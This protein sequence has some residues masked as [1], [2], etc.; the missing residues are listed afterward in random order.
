MVH[1]IDR[2]QLIL[3]HIISLKLIWVFGFNSLISGN[4]IGFYAEDPTCSNDTDKI[5]PSFV[6]CSGPGAIIPRDGA[7]CVCGQGR[8]V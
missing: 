3:N 2:F 8:K 5:F 7:S 6:K 1:S 4:F